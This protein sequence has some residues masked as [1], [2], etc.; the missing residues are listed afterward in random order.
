MNIYDYAEKKAVSIRQILDLTCLTNPLGPSEKAKHAMRKALKNLGNSPDRETR[1]LRREIARRNRIDPA[2]ILFGHGATFLLG[3][4]LAAFKPEKVLVPAPVPAYYAELIAGHGGQCLPFPLFEGDGSSIAVGLLS[5]IPR[6][7]GM[8]ILPNPHRLTGGVVP[9]ETLEILERSFEGSERLIVVDEA[10]AEFTEAASPVE[11]AT[12][13]NNLLVLRSFSLFHCL[14]GLPLGYCVAC[15]RI[16]GAMTSVVDPGPVS[17]IASAGALAS[18]R[19]KGFHRR[20]GEYLR[21]EKAY[22]DEKL[23]RVDG[24]ETIDRGCSF[25]VLRLLKAVPDLEERLLDKR[26]LVELFVD[27][28]GVPFLR[29]PIRSHRENARFAKTLIRVMGQGR[30]SG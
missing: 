10:L 13:S 24:V 6:E 5:S 25:L 9:L 3:V 16:I 2:S 22:F 12:T 1:Y 21:V 30:P 15:P 26:I 7:A 28:R 4:L 11:R 14:A 19:D 8:V 27:D 23:G 20:T 18:L 17:V 29:V